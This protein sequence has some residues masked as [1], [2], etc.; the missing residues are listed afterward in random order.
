MFPSH[1]TPLAISIETTGSGKITRNPYLR[2]IGRHSKIRTPDHEFIFNLNGEIKFIRGLNT[3][4]PHP[5]EQL[6]RTDGND[7][8]HYTVGDDSTENGIISWMGDY[9]LPCLPYPS[10]A[11]WDINYRENPVIMMAFASW[12]Q[13][14]ANLYDGVHQNTLH[15]NAMDLARKILENDDQTLFNR[16]RQLKEITGEEISVLPPD[17][18][19]V[20]YELIP[21]TIADGCLY[22]CKFCCVKSSQKFAP[23]TRKQ[24]LEQIQHLKTFYGRNLENYNAL[25]LGNH[26]AMAAG[27]DLICDTASTAFEA[28]G[29][30]HGQTEVQGY[31]KKQSGCFEKHPGCLEKHPGSLK[32]A[33]R[34][35]MFASADSLLNAKDSMFDHLD[36]LRFKTYINVG[37]ESLDPA[38]LKEIGKPLTPSKVAHA[39]EKI[40]AINNDFP[41]IEVTCNFLIG[42][43]LGKDHYD[44]L[45]SLLSNAPKTRNCKGT[46]YLSPVQ[47]SPKKKELLPRIR[48]INKQSNLPVFVYLIQRF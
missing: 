27:Q 13:L 9:Y 25:F 33:P 15:P 4:W 19:H 44:S 21:L 18:R 43:D 37:L 47:N 42:T 6:K 31:F 28:F 8:V 10:N 23:R 22:H 41:N 40:C 16:S 7:W 3:N 12:S 35:F 5:S 34:M 1:H 11:V 17:T 29:F 14:F 26:D 32:E 36:R 45:V 24:I 2:K 46:V 38:T 48:E 39:F 30:D 20:D